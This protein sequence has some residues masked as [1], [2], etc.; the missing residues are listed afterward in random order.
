M[1]NVTLILLNLG[2]WVNC[3]LIRNNRTIAVEWLIG[4]MKMKLVELKS[5][6]IQ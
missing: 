6:I 4:I 5:L 3:N 1:K 2:T